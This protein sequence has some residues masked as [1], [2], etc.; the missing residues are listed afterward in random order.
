MISMLRRPQ[1]QQ[2]QQFF[3]EETAFLGTFLLLFLAFVFVLSTGNSLWLHTQKTDCFVFS[4]L[5]FALPVPIFT[6][7]SET[8]STTAWVTSQL[9][10]LTIHLC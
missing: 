8:A 3:S 9:P 6:A 4:F 7:V 5:S 10:R 1:Q 2:Q